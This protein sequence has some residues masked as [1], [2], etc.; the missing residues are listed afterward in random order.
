[1]THAPTR[2]ATVLPLTAVGRDDLA[3]AGGKGANLGE[4]IRAGFPVPDGVV[5]T[6]DAYAAV[7][8]QA[9]LAPAL[10]SAADDGGAALRAA[11]AAV[12]MPDD[13]R[14]AILDIHPLLG[15]GP[16]AV[17][18]SAT[19]EDLPGAAFAG[20]QDTYLNVV[21]PEALLDAVRRCWGSLWTERAIAYR[22]RR[23]V[24]PAAVRIAVVVQRMVPAAFAGVLFTA[25]PV[26]GARDEVVVDASSG[27]GEAVVSG[28][29]TPDHYVL[30]AD[31]QVRERRRG[32]REVVVRGI[33][34]GGV[35]HCE[36]G[37]HEELPDTVLAELAALGRRVADHFGRPQD[38]EWAWAD[39]RVWLVQARP[40]T[41]LPPPPLHLSR[42]QRISG[43]QIVEYLPYRPYPMDTSGWIDRGIG[44]MVRRML[45]EIA[46]VHIDFADV[47][48]ESDGVVDRFVPPQPRPTLEVLGAPARNLPRI[49]RYRPAGW[50]RDPRYTRFEREVRELAAV[51]VPALGWDE[52]RRLPQRT[53]DTTDLVTDL[54][55]DYLPRVGVDLL[56]LRLLQVLLRRSGV[57]GLTLGTR[58]RTEDAN[59]ELLRLAERVRA[60]GALRTVFGLEPDA[61]AERI[62]QDPAFADFR[63]AFAAFRAEYGHRETASPLLMSA[64]TWGD[65]PAIVLGMVKVLVADAPPAPA[66]DRAER[67]EQQLLTHPLVRLTR[68]ER[69]VRG[70]LA[71]ARSGIAFREDTHFHGTRLLPVLRRAVLEMGRRLAA[72]D[73]LREADDVLHLRLEELEGLAD[74]AT[75][76][77]ADAERVRATARARSAR[78]AELAGVPLIASSVL[79]P[80]R[81]P[82]GDALVTGTPASGG[83]ATGPVRV[84]RE[85]A[86]FGRLRSGD[87]L[88]CPYTNPSWTPL[89]QRAAA[90]VVDSGGA[91]SHAAIVAREYGIPAVMGSATGTSVLTD[92]QVVTVDGDTGLVT[93]E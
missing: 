28:L 86:G 49:R 50:T 84:I 82:R 61:I 77:P 71:G 66:A 23:D 8:E 36:E 85:T 67:A 78:R 37:R 7:V 48:P 33:D 38:I 41:A 43:P 31:G 74:P 59:R 20:Q 32:L 62:E 45:R 60:D 91:G 6:T 51:D 9:G 10:A 16:V 13:L 39:G 90:V 40:M 3:S 93:G 34:G 47:L 92:G 22:A 1:M 12:E 87:V 79:F 29:V 35:E 5:I 24:D 2:P 42:I 55:V 27:L 68:S 17:R 70:L 19:A 72:A 46:G 57:S 52:L 83:R 15:G 80:D 26:S 21:G 25:N 65:A 14:K 54:R 53:F 4:L 58:T 64:P 56:R 30:G 73:V 63:A 88:V 18:S 69:R 89:F 76:A 11:F 75:L 81:A 44:R